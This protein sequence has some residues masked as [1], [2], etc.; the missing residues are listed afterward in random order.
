MN[1]KD[2][3]PCLLIAMP[4]LQDPNFKK[5]VVLLTAYNDAGGAHGLVINRAT[6]MRLGTTVRFSEGSLNPNYQD[7]PLWYGGPVEPQQLWILYDGNQ[8]HNEADAALGD[9]IWLAHNVSMLMREKTIDMG[10]CRVIHGYAGWQGTQLAAE[11]AIS[12]WI[13]APV[14]KKLVFDT[15]QD[16]IWETAV[17]SLGF[18]P[19]NLVGPKTPYLN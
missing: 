5:T 3:I 8:L 10:R 11:I 9:G 19:D 2:T 7:V 17:R 1:F 14:S 12:C 16:K 13:T 15:P 4:E 18:N 6:P